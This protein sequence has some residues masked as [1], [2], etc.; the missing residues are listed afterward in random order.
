MNTAGLTTFL[1]TAVVGLVILVVGI[2]VIARASKGD[3]KAV[4]STVGILLVGLLILGLAVGN[5]ATR[6]G[7]ALS[8]IIFG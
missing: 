6:V 2:I 4:M 7:G 3:H 5:N 1:T 8:K